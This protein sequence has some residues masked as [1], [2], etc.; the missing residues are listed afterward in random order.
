GCRTGGCAG[1]VSAGA[2]VARYGRRGHAALV[3]GGATGLERLHGGGAGP[4]RITGPARASRAR[5]GDVLAA[6]AEGR[7]RGVALAGL[8]RVEDVAAVHARLGAVVVEHQRLDAGRG[9]AHG[10]GGAEPGVA[11][12]H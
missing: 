1:D 3:A 5:E 8:E 11:A 12:A 4:A 6:V 7:A 10:V 2:A 9:G